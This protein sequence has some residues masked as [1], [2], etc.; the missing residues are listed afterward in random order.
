MGEEY[1]RE[2]RGELGKMRRE[3]VSEKQMNQ[4]ED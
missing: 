2:S 1:N 4:G 3:K